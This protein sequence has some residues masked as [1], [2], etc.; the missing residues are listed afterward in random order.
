M[1]ENYGRYYY[2]GPVLE[3]GRIIAEHWTGSTYAP[4]TQRAKSN[5]AYQFKKQNNKVQAS[6][7]SLPG[8]IEKIG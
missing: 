4:T 2:D 3:F 7:I 8:K 1:S 5:L 6:K